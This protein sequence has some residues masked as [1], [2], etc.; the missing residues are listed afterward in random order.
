MPPLPL[1]PPYATEMTWLRKVPMDQ[2]TLKGLV[3]MQ[4]HQDSRY[5]AVQ[6]VATLSGS[7]QLRSI[8]HKASP[9]GVCRVAGANRD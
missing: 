8:Y 4:A 2:S 6:T 9:Q 3:Q 7:R 1:G 5:R